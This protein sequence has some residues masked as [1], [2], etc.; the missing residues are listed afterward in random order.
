MAAVGLAKQQLA[1]SSSSSSSNVTEMLMM[2][3]SASLCL[4]CL[5]PILRCFSDSRCL[6]ALLLILIVLSPTCVCLQQLANCLLVSLELFADNFIVMI[7]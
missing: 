3:T 6:L 4:P 7:S 2:Q 5:P 1:A